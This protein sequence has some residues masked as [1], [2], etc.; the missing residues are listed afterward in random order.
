MSRFIA[1]KKIAIFFLA[2]FLFVFI[3]DVSNAQEFSSPDDPYYKNQW[4]L[5]KVGVNYSWDYPLRGQVPVIAII[6]SG[7]DI[8]HPDLIKNIWKNSAEISN[9][10]IDDDNNGFIDDIY[11]WNFVE[12]TSDPRPRLI[13]SA[14]DDGLNHGTM[15]AGIVAATVNNDIGISGIANRS[16]IMALRSL[17]DRGEGKISDV[18]RAI[19]YAINNGADIIN[20]SFSGSTY[21]QA[22]KDTIGR[23]HK[24][25]LM[26]VSAVGNSNFNLNKNPSYPACFD[27]EDGKNEVIGVSAVDTLDQKASFSSYGLKCVDISAPGVSFFSSSFYDLATKDYAEYT[28]YWSGTSMAAA[29]VSGTL[30]LIKQVNPKLGKEEVEE[31]LFKSSDNIDLLNPGY[32]ES[33]GVGR[34]NVFNSI[35]WADEKWENLSGK[36]VV[37]P[38][39]EVKSYQSEDNIYSLKFTNRKGVVSSSF[40]VYDDN[41][42]GGVNVA[43]GDLDGD[44]ISEIVTGAGQGGGP[45]VRIFDISGNLKSQFF[46]YDQNF[47]GGVNVSVGDL[48]GDGMSEIVTGAGQ[49]GGP[50]VRIFDMGGNLKGQFFAYDQNFR[51][52]VNVAVGDLYGDGFGEIITGAGPGGGPHVRVFDYQANLKGQFFAY[53]ESF[54]GGVKV[55]VADIYGN[56]TKNK[57]E[58]IVAPGPGRLAEVKIFDTLGKERKKI[59]AYSEKFKNGVNLSVGDLNKNGLDEIIL[60]AGSGGAPHVR[61][62]NGKGE[63]VE[64]FY[65]LDEKFSGGVS[66]T[67]I[68]TYN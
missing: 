66:A 17:D 32:S 63:L 20:L 52:G 34:V 38:Q 59:L 24:A 50:H 56:E 48:D 54:R 43:I 21:N 14:N 67:Y 53:E 68:E 18:I 1:S 11:G 28:G 8:E 13:S 47:R 29:V 51:G 30:G 49:G 6:D 58:I 19:D 35:R 39:S 57:R 12:N 7:I 22:F 4:Y 46:A 45:Q 27:S 16:K 42:H 61:A 33:L 2:F 36:F 5:K 64:S 10:G 65:A 62:F 9:N 3:A 23:A 44:G 60:G 15:I 26:V 40:N 41:F 25:G 37:Y 55:A 31:V